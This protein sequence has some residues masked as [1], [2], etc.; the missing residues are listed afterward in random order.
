MTEG[1]FLCLDTVKREGSYME[2]DDQLHNLRHTTAHLL[3]AA[4]LELYPDAKPTIG[5]VIENGFYYDF[6]FPKPISEEDLSKIEEKMRELLKSWNKV[7]HREV[8]AEEAKKIFKNNPY[9]L[10]LIEDLE[11]DNQPISLYKTGDFEDLCRGGH[12]ENPQD[13]KAFKLLSLAGAYWRGDEKNKM[14]TRIYGTAFPTQKDL[15]E[16]LSMLEEAKK[17]DH[18]KLGPQLG[19]FMFHETAPGMPYWLPKGV[20]LLNEL[21]KFWRE[22]HYARGYQEIISP[23]LNKKELYVTSGHWDH[24]KEDMF[25]AETEE[26]EI[27][28]VKPMNCPNA[29]VVYGS[30]VRS[31]K[32]LPLR[33][34]DTDTLH[35][36]ERSGTLNGLLRVREFRQDDAHIFVTEDQIKDEYKRIFEI[37]EKFYSI[38]N[39]NYSFRLGTR[40]ENFM[41]DIKSWDKAEETLKEILK[42]SGK[43]HFILEGDGA[44]YGPKVDILMKDSL[45]RD[46]Q[47]GTVQLDFQLPKNFNLKYIDADG[48]EKTPVT[49]HRVVYGS[50][51]RFIGILI[52]HT[53]GALPTWIAPIQAE[54]I[55]ITDRNIAYGQKILNQLK[56]LNIRA[57]IDDRSE[58]MQLKIRNAQ[59]QK[60]PYMLIIGDREQQAGQVAVRTR[61][62][63]DLGAIPV[64]QFIETVKKEI[65]SKA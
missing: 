12:L 34:G 11:K 48:K 35:R 38:F 56:D 24:Y 57:E 30:Q 59:M 32:D 28:G 3:A 18:R 54:I 60:I 41:G 4:V 52:E 8:S 17:R 61:E 5:P 26:G 51:E 49:I 27:Y 33:L 1:I 13:I 9:K 55:P 58:K 22:E 42:E 43:E 37:V 23:L 10:E 47:M 14:L 2:K 19:L 20:T 65:E 50:L 31:Y 36:A 15:D 62:G 29:M 64:E 46:W 40:P 16:Y 21:I 53:A 6:D 63:K 45:E 44:F 39:I 7:E 25:L